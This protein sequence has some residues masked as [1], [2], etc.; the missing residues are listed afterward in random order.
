MARPRFSEMLYRRRRE[1]GVSCA[2]ASRALRIKE[3]ALVAF[4]E[5]DWDNIPKSGYAQGMISS[6]ARYLGLN[7]R[8][9]I[10]QFS[11]DVEEWEQGAGKRAYNARGRGEAP[12]ADKA[13]SGSRGLLPTSGGY[14]GDMASFSTVSSVHSRGNYGT[15]PRE[16]VREEPD[17]G[18]RPYTL[19]QPGSLGTA[20]AARATAQRMQGRDHVRVDD[21]GMDEGRRGA[22]PQTRPQGRP[23]PGYRPRVSVPGQR[24]AGYGRRMPAGENV[25]TRRVDVGDYVDDLRYDD[26]VNPYQ[27]ASTSG[28]RVPGRY[29]D[30]P[31]R[32]NVRRRQST[33]SRSELRNREDRRSKG[34]LADLLTDRGN[35][36]IVIVIGLAIVLTVLIITSVHSCY[37]QATSSG[38]ES[39]PVESGQGSSDQT[40]TQPAMMPSEED[41]AAGNLDG[42]GSAGSA[43]ATTPKKVEV[44]VAVA[45]GKVTWLEVTVDGESKYADDVTGPWT[46]TYDVVD[47]IKVKAAN[48][49]VVTVEKNGEPQ[50]FEDKASGV[51]TITIKGS[52]VKVEDT[53]ADEGKDSSSQNS[54]SES[55]DGASQSQE[56]GAKNDTGNYPDYYYDES[57]GLYYDDEGNYYDDY[58]NQ[59]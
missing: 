38:R 27:A 18:D 1:M 13:N 8:V 33:Q 45:S 49:K 36:L 7:P 5:G 15:Y 3:Q 34:G 39:V 23:R 6:Y 46:E 16:E 29:V 47:S 9:V 44:T 2:D 55:A 25:T 40:Q 32:P 37:R 54:D 31:E 41:L 14:A 59:V 26:Q 43:A 11:H 12:A 51:G 42:S 17:G 53:A 4:E 24:E 56:N 57:L 50:T 19:R 21:Y 20:R 58:G 35:I 52:G 10:N 48:P 22:E 30:P 28:G